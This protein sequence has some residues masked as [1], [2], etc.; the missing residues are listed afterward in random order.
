MINLEYIDRYF[1]GELSAEEIIDF[2]QKISTDTGFAE[3]VFLYC[4][5]MQLGREKLGLEKKER[6]RELY[7][8]SKEKKKSTAPGLV[9]K[10]WPYVAAAAVIAGIIFGTLGH[11]KPFSL[12]QNADRF[13]SQR[14]ETVSVQMGNSGDSLQQAIGMYNENKLAESLPLFERIIQKEEKTDEAKKMAGIVSLRLG[15]YDKAI[16]YFSALEA[17]PLFSNPGKFYHALTLIKR[18]RAGDREAAIS[19]LKQVVDENL[20]EKETAADWLEDH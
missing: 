7:R 17:L 4:S 8:L 9:R 2:D 16:V 1:K 15:E 18:N 20:E 13:I 10:W 6:F 3:E 12:Q 14:L 19:L 5:A 11:F